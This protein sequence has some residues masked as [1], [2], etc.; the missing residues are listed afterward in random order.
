MRPLA[1]AFVVSTTKT[2]TFPLRTLASISTA[3]N[4]SIPLS[5][6]PIVDASAGATYVVEL[7]VPFEHMEK[8][9]W[10]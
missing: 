10:T 2:V 1:Q 3:G 5:Q 7:E 6:L 9:M 4:G 8:C